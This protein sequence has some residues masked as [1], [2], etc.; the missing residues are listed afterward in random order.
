[1]LVRWDGAAG[2]A[3][4]EMN[5]IGTRVSDELRGIPGVVNVGSHFG[6]AVTSD[7]AVGANAG[8]VWAS[9]SP[10]ADYDRTVAAIQDVTAGYPGLDQRLITYSNQRVNDIA[11]SDSAPVTVRVY[12]DDL[13]VL[14]QKAD[15]IRAAIAGVDG[16]ESERV[17]S[18]S[19]EP[20]IQVEVDLAKAR[21][22]GV[23]PGDVRRAATTLLAGIQVGSIFD[24]NKVFDVVVWSPPELRK[25]LTDVRNLLI[26]T[27]AGGHVRLGQVA[28]V[29]IVGT[30]S[31]ISHDAVSR[32]VDVTAQVSGRDL[33]AVLDDVRD[34]LATVKFPL[35][36]HA[37]VLEDVAED[38]ADQRDLMLISGFAALGLFLLLQS[39]FGSWR[40]ALVGLLALPLCLAG[41]LLVAVLDGGALTLSTVLGLVGVAAFGVRA[42]IA[43]F[44]RLERLR[45]EGELTG[46]EL[47]TRAAHDRVLPVLATSLTTVLALVPLLVLGPRSGLEILRPLAGVMAGGLIS[48]ALVVLLVLPPLF[49]RF[50]V[51]RP[52]KAPR[53][54]GPPAVAGVP[55]A[56]V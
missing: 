25:N 23:K 29:K 49:L 16:L 1:M 4:P 28:D 33:D 36:Y 50:T 21:V 19:A 22:H 35:E 11:T 45:G 31:T 46:P 17:S 52:G 20:T 2:T 41:G 40:L 8:M 44:Q 48:T 27:P 51:A 53:D 24:N 13:A 38:Q 6:R 43:L 5:R 39:A 30:P 15:E 3:L 56:S 55:S 12:G 32:R 26:D 7:Q 34:R 10:D 37:E 47:V 54:A 42:M 18:A 9:I 14:Q